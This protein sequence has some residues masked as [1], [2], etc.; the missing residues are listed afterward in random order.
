M[1]NDQSTSPRGYVGLW[2]R[3]FGKR[4]TVDMPLPYGGTKSVTV[5]EKWMEL[6]ETKR[7]ARDI[8][9][10]MIRV[11][12]IDD[13]AQIGAETDDPEKLLDSILSSGPT[14]RKEVWHVGVSVPQEVCAKLADPETGELY[15][16]ARIQNGTKG[17]KL[18][19]RKLWEVARQAIEPKG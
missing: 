8:S 15:G 10:Q 19:Q 5:T 4:I 1:P 12:I 2:D 17:V 7:K 9:S 6:M 3:L 16:I 13:S 18:M 14:I 11:N